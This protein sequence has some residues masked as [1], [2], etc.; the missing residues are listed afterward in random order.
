VT[1]DIPSAHPPTTWLAGWV[2]PD[3]LAAALDWVL[4]AQGRER[5]S[6]WKHG[7]ETWER[8]AKQRGFE[9]FCWNDGS[10][11]R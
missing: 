7:K 4:E 10:L 11:N 6:A 2:T 9:P 8:Y 5:R 3:D 1:H